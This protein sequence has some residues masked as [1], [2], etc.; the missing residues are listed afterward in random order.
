M[1]RL[2]FLVLFLAVLL[3]EVYFV[4]AG[5]IGISPN[6]YDVNFEPGLEQNFSFSAA[7]ADPDRSI[8]IY[9]KGDLAEYVSLSK[10][11]LIGSGSFV[12]S[13]SLPDE[14]EKPGKHRILVGVIEQAEEQNATIGSV[15]AVQAY[16]DVHVPYPGKY[17]EAEFSVSDINEGESAPYKLLI[18]NLGTDDFNVAP[19]IEF[20]SDEEKVKTF[21][22]ENSLIKSKESKTFEG[23]FNTS[24]LK[25]GLYSV[26]AKMDYGGQP[27]EIEKEFRVGTL[28]VNITDYSSKFVPG[29][30]NKFDIEIESLWNLEIEN[31]YSEVSV[32][33]EGDILDSFRTPSVNLKPWEKTNLTGFFDAEN[34]TE[35]KYK[36]AITVYYG[37][38]SNYKLVAIR[39]REPFE[40]NWLY[41]TAGIVLLVFIA[42]VIY[43]VIKIRRLR[44][45]AKSKR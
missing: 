22:L 1:K 27:L 34:V 40:L 41:V 28:F 10:S 18:K 30:I 31:V 45:N 16:I 38:S 2:I 3:G 7:S 35:G 26:V 5:S 14:I 36:A 15:A 12:V 33:G 13:I 43:L 44:K 9:I 21:F 4:S 8:G 19:V 6:G 23:F 29:R 37:N 20:Y 11:S 42:I 17:A 25:S 39:V 24:D 32:T